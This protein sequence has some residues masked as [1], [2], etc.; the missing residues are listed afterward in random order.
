VTLGRLVVAVLAVVGAVLLQV[1]LL[2]RLGLPG[3]TPDLV[4]VVVLAFG[5]VRGPTTGAGVG[6]AAGLLVDLIPPSLGYFGLTALLLAIA[7]YLMGVVAERTGGVVA[8]SLITVAL[9]SVGLVFGR[10][11]IGTL[12]GDPRVSWGEVPGLALTEAVY[13][14]ILAA[15]VIPT[16]AAIDRFLEPRLSL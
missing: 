10:A 3:A 8:I 11:A 7:G 15:L 1:T 6:F 13:T 9:I 14:V 12:L 4:L 2:S 5:A 16:L